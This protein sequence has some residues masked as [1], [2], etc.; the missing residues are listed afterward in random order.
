MNL[1]SGSPGMSVRASWKRLSFGFA[2]EIDRA[3]R[4]LAAVDHPYHANQSSGRC[5]VHGAA[6]I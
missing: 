4:V 1:L 2:A 5:I 6:E 3:R